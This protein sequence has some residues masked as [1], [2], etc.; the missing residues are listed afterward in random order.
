MRSGRGR[1]RDAHAL[2]VAARAP[3][4]FVRRAEGTQ[5]ATRVCGQC[6][7]VGDISVVTPAV[8]GAVKR[9]A[10]IATGAD[11]N[12]W[13]AQFTTGI[14][15]SVSPIGSHSLRAPGAGNATR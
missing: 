10:G 2:G 1:A 3:L 8:S 15:G 11:G 5:G 14:A 7:S 6:R 4:P 9:I 12:I 13:D